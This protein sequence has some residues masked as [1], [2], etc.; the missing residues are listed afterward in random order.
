MFI[1]H[2]G[3]YQKGAREPGRGLSHSPLC[4]PLLLKQGMGSRLPRCQKYFTARWTECKIHT[5]T[6]TWLFH[7]IFKELFSFCNSNHFTCIPISDPCV[8]YASPAMGRGGLAPL[9]LTQLRGKQLR[10]PFC[11]RCRGNFIHV[12]GQNVTTLKTGYTSISLSSQ[13]STNDINA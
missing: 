12:Y 3:C 2:R 4:C 13:G 1:P 10:N 7:F 9:R 5:G 6:Q 11:P 8:R